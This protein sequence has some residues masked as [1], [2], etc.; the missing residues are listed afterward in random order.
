MKKI[1]NPIC[2]L[3]PP[4]GINVSEVRGDHGDED[5]EEEL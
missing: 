1:G 4:P 3:M 2:Y 5:E